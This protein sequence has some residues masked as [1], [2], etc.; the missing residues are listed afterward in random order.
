[1]SADG[2]VRVAGQEFDR[3]AA[4]LRDVPGKLLQAAAFKYDR[5]M[6]ATELMEPKLDVSLQKSVKSVRER[7]VA[8]E[9][10]TLF[11]DGQDVLVVFD[12]LF[13]LEV[14]AAVPRRWRRARIPSRCSAAHHAA[15]W[16]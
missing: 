2:L 15:C 16:S 8:G 12:K 10:S 4:F 14:W 9:L 1:V 7:I 13:S 5:A 6:N 3:A 11:E